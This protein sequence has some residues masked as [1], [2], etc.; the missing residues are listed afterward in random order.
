M[1]DSLNLGG[2][3][4]NAFAFDTVGAQVTGR[5]VDLE[6]VQQTNMDDG[7]PSFWPD[8]KPRMMY[9]VTLATTLRDSG[10]PADDGRRSVYLRGSVKPE[11]QSSLA[12]VIAAV[13]A[14]TGGT[15][16]KVGGTLTLQY[17]GDG[18]ASQRGFNPPKQY[19]A[20]YEPPAVTLGGQQA[21]APPQ[22]QQAPMQPVTTQQPIV[23]AQTIA[24][25]AAA[26][27]V[28]QQTPEQVAALAALGITPEQLA[29]LAAANAGQ[30]A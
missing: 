8:G 5:I 14:A 19:A 16:I 1:P 25:P 2:D 29:A 3:G 30:P 23:P 27:A 7:Q 24:Q 26:P 22:Q 11:S 4:G 21:A 9:R 17:V 12:A 10:D 15:D 6:E 13:R 20:A 18:Q 28:Q